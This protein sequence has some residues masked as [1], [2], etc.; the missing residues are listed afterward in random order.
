MPF[1]K[2]AGA[3]VF[4]RDY[5]LP[6]TL[7]SQPTHPKKVKIF[8]LLLHY[9]STSKAPKPHSRANSLRGRDYW[10]FPKGHIERGE[11]ELETVKRE[12]EEETGLTDLEFMEDFKEWIKYFFRHKGKTVFKIV[13]F[14]LAETKKEAVK[15]S[16]E[17]IGYQWLPYKEALKTLN[18]KNAK[19]I[20]KKA[21]K[22]LEKL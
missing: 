19:D 4:R 18:F 14:Y 13:T 22:F 2:S 5:D 11:K 3:V 7:Q 21:N 1:E 20:L 8:Y 15:T 10:D 16:F 17:H 6:T 9:P 12:V